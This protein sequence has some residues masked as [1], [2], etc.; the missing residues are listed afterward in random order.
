[1]KQ[2]S[3][4]TKIDFFNRHS[5]NWGM[6]F[7]DEEIERIEQLLMKCGFGQ[8][9]RILEPGC[10][11]GFITGAIAERFPLCSITAIDIS[12]DM[13]RK[14]QSFLKSERVRFIC[15]D[16]HK[17]GLPGEFFTSILCFNCFPHFD[18]K[19][20]VLR[21]F[22]RLLSPGGRLFVVHSISRQMVNRIHRQCGGAVEKDML[23]ALNRLGEISAVAGFKTETAEEGNDFFFFSAH[24]GI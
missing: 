18:N 14:A 11:T 7:T 6:N 20:K 8:N 24:K 21:E 17:T 1:M 3:A 19:T 9:E 5:L 4:D 13:L 22:H 16:A 12:P 15:A 10:G 2:T 23:P